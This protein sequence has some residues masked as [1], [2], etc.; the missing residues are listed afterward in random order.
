MDRRA[1]LQQTLAVTAGATLLGRADAED[2][3]AYTPLKNSV[4]MGMFPDELSMDERV[5]MAKA[6][7]FDGIEMS[8]MTDMDEAKRL[9]DVARKEGIAIHSIIYGGWHAPLSDPDPKVVARGRED[10]ERAMQTAQ[11]VGADNVLL[12]PA[13]VNEKVRYIEA[14]ERSAKE[15][16]S[17]IPLAEKYGV[18]I[19][20]EEVWNKFLLSPLE[21]AKYIDDFKSKWVRAYFDVGN[22]VIYGYPE[23]WIRTLGDRIIRVHIKDFKRDGYQWKALYEG[24]V[25]W[26]EVRKA[27]HEIGYTGWMNAELP[28]GD[29]DYL[30]EVHRRMMLIGQGAKSI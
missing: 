6:C 12:V 26:A 10:V 4:L 29:E 20:V 5:K 13:V 9:G 7:G 11:A 3:P 27:F 21:F 2:A 1:F 18:I 16:T 25:N 22:V 23:D 17:L 15:I 30:R 28:K 8:P 24:D 19:G 14:Y